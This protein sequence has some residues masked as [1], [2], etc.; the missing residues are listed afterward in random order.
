[1]DPVER[2]DKDSLV[3]GNKPPADPDDV[4]AREGE[5]AAGTSAGAQEAALEDDEWDQ[6]D[7]VELGGVVMRGGYCARQG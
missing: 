4:L 7:A 6:E 2:R 5:E 3:P 1:V